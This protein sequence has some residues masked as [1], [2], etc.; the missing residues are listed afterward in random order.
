MEIYLNDIKSWLHRHP[1][2]KKIKKPLLEKLRHKA[3]GKGEISPALLWSVLGEVMAN[4]YLDETAKNSKAK[5][6]GKP[7]KQ[8]KTT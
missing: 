2:L 6:Q 4:W 7:S 3:N 8:R 1:E 5:S